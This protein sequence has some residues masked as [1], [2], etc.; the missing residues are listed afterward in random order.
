VD[1]IA[2]VL[3]QNPSIHIAI[4]GH[5]DN[6]ERN[7]VPLG[8]SR[9][10]AVQRALVER[11]VEKARLQL[12]THGAAQPITQNTTAEDRARNRRTEFLITQAYG[13]AQHRQV[14]PIPTRL[15]RRD[16]IGIIRAMLRNAGQPPQGDLKTLRARLDPTTR[17]AYFA[18]IYTP[19][20]LPEAIDAADWKALPTWAKQ[21]VLRLLIDHEDWARLRARASRQLKL[22]DGP[23]RVRYLAGADTPISEICKGEWK[24][25]TEVLWPLAKVAPKRAKQL[26]ALALRWQVRP[27]QAALVLAPAD[28]PARL[29]ALT[30]SIDRPNAVEWDFRALAQLAR[31]IQADAVACRAWKR[32]QQLSR[33]PL[34]GKSPCVTPPRSP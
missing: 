13:R 3:K 28:D 26:A 25:C 16:R 11:G 21:G 33:A 8:L 31:S 34:P 24:R 27:N 5:T 2:E 6:R 18:W 1:Q 14:L 20:E 19:K 4:I 10:L 29:N 15:S 9:A 12:R 30:R 22:L 32:A 7:A 23:D 17:L